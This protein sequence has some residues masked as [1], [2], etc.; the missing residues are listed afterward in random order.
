MRQPRKRLCRSGGDSVTFG[1]RRALY[2]VPLPSATWTRRHAI[3]CPTAPENA[4]RRI[5]F[6]NPASERENDVKSNKEGADKGQRDE[7]DIGRSAVNILEFIFHKIFIFN[8]I[9]FKWTII[10]KTAKDVLPIKY[11]ADIGHKPKELEKRPMV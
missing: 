9:I 1:P 6:P 11:A 4:L 5:A 10:I 3:A 2:C 7:R 8:K